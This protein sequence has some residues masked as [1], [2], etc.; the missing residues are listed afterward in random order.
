MTARRDLLVKNATIVDVVTHTTYPGWFSVVGG[1][2]AEVETGVP[3]AAFEKAATTVV[4]LDGAYVQPGML[5]IHMHIES[6]LVTPRRFAEAA[7]PHGTTTI[8]QDP[9][10]V[11]NVLGAPGVRWMLEASRGLPLRVYT[12]VSSCVPATSAAIETPNAAISPA[13]VTQLAREPEVIALGEMM[14]FHG[15]IDGDDHLSAMLRA[16]AEAGLTLEG[17][18]PSLTGPELSRYIAHGIRSDHTL[19]TPRKLLEQLRKGM[20]VMIQEKSLTHEVVATIMGL[21]DRSRVLLITDD[22]MP[23]RLTTGH[24]DRIVRRAVDTGWEP[25][26]ALAA[27]TVRPATYL[28]LHS[29]GT[30]TPGAEADFV[31]TPALATYPPST[32]YVAGRLVATAG[33][34]VVPSLPSPQPQ[35]VAGLVE[36]FDARKFGAG[37][38]RFSGRETAPAAG[39]ER[40][41]RLR[42]R[43]IEANDE[44][45]F[46]TLAERDVD[47][48]EGAPVDPGLVMATVIPRATARPGAAPYTPVMV[49]IA[50][51][52]LSSGA[53]ATTF[54]HDSHNV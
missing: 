4:D 11:A 53:Y 30:I 38:F 33:T 45:S 10:E 52:G 3:G 2:F 7:L 16:G 21:A 50:G 6:S 44:N 40:R 32:V 34:T 1:R 31:V 42:A 43:V 27:A 14:D 36:S 22:V 19:M 18:V 9:H 54:A 48:E 5:D 12:A 41:Q 28:G 15:L 51:L 25:V 35:D 13:E 37:A 8:L 26:D 17:H 29:L 24:L 49:L 46:T 47:F 39:D 20:W 23:N